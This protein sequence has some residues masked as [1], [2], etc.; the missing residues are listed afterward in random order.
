MALIRGNRKASPLACRS[1]GC[2]V[3]K[4]TSKTV[5][6]WTM[7]EAHEDLVAANPTNKAKFKDVLEYL[8]QDLQVSR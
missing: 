3:S 1:L 5:S 4:A 6:G 2:T 8:R 7:L